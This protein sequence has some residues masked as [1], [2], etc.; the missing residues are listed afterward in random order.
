MT[1]NQCDPAYT[2]QRT[3]PKVVLI[4][5]LPEERRRLLDAVGIYNHYDL[6]RGILVEEGRHLGIRQWLW[7]F[8]GL[9]PIPLHCEP[10]ANQHNLQLW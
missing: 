9:M 5:S 6:H 7:R 3:S 1:A 8:P 2:E 10:D 4:E